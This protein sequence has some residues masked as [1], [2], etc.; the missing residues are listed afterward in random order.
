MSSD[1]PG[2]VFKRLETDA[3]FIA[4]LPWRPYTHQTLE[5]DWL[6]ECA[7]QVFKMQRKIVED[8]R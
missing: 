6:D 3:E 1:K 4:R 2:T 8:E 5:G 7:W